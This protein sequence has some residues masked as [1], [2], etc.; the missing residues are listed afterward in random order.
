MLDGRLALPALRVYDSLHTVSGDKS[1][2]F[3]CDLA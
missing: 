2:L 3:I 1:P